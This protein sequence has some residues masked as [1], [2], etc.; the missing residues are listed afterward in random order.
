M[1]IRAC[2]DGRQAERRTTALVAYFSAT[3]NTKAAAETLAEVTGADLYR[4]EPQT[5]YTAADLDWRDSLSRS[6]VE[7]N[8]PAARPVMS[9]RVDD[10]GRYDTI[11]IGYPIWWYVCPRIINSFIEAHDLTGKV[12]YVF[13]TSGSSR[14]DGSLKALRETYPALEWKDGATLNGAT[15]QTVRQWLAGRA[16]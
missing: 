7:M 13:A 8:D 9:G 3:G 14:V 16:R 10:I 1:S 12:L 6:S 5:P 15:E 4:I 11:Y 2:A